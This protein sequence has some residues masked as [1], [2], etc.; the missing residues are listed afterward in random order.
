M[1]R[2]F[3]LNSL[4]AAGPDQV[5][6]GQHP[7]TAQLVRN[8]EMGEICYPPG[9]SLGCRSSYGGWFPLRLRTMTVF[10]SDS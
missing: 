6:R 1:T 3:W 8:L 4:A 2:N 5:L 10:W 7:L 9:A